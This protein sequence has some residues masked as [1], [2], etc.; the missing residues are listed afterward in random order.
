MLGHSNP[1]GHIMEFDAVRRDCK[2]TVFAAGNGDAILIEAHD[3]TV[4]TDIH[5]RR[6]QAED[7][8]NDWVPD[9]APDIRAACPDDRLQV[10]VL[11]HPDKDHTH[12]FEE[13]FHVGT[14]DTWTRYPRED[15]PK[16][17]VEEIWCCPYAV[18]PYYVTEHAKPL[19]DEIKRRYLLQGSAAAS[20]PGNKLRVM[21]MDGETRGSVVPGLNW[22]LL[23]PTKDEWNIPKALEGETPTSSNPTS[24][25][26]RWTVTVDGV[27]SLILLG[28]DSI[29]DIW[30]R[31]ERDIHAEAPDDLAWHILVAAH[32]CSRRSLGHV[33]NSSN[34][35]IDFEESESAM[36]AL[37]E[38]R[39]NGY[40]VSSSKRL[41]HLKPSPPSHHAKNRYL[42]ILAKGGEVDDA[43]RKRFICTGGDVNSDK[44]AHAIFNLTGSGPTRGHRPKA[45]AIAT[46]VGVG[47]SSV[48]RGGGYG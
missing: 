29:V 10:F 12:G 17:L 20:I 21:D 25:V 2:L 47:S 9:F 35:D 45:P 31:I 6:D 33:D 34:T 48:G 43:V 44:P 8:E 11:T 15:G 36:R 7:D 24:L 23:A 32:H 38:M 22:R 16:I 19:L 41:N 18:K 30:E 46:G 27:D 37:G 26:I 14:P 13:I 3:Q 39:G 40:V 1:F 5:Y 28:G 4:M 42:K